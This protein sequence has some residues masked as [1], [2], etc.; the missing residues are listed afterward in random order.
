MQLSLKLGSTTKI[1]ELD[2][3]RK[4]QRAAPKP[5]EKP[6]KRTCIFLAFTFKYRQLLKKNKRV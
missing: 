3:V 2:S 4:D 5:G 1:L 6:E